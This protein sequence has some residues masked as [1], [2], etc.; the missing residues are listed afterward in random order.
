MVSFTEPPQL[1]LSEESHGILRRL[2][3]DGYF[4]EMQDAF[5][6]AV[7]LALSREMLF[8]GEFKKRTTVYSVSTIDT[9][10]NLYAVTKSLL[11]N[12]NEPVYQT[13]ERLAEW[14]LGY[15]GQLAE[16]GRI[17]FASLFPG[18]SEG[19]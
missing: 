5:L 3:Q 6:F 15:L 19:K 2:E 16:S 14:G 18:D 7:G 11:P 1:K 9:N 12:R 13:V 4:K 8:E 17:E 10:Q